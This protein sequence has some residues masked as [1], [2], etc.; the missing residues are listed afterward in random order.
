MHGQDQDDARPRQSQNLEQAAC[1]YRACLMPS[2]AIP[3]ECKEILNT[4]DPYGGR[5]LAPSRLN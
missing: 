4:L 3:V 1:M 5:G 2:A